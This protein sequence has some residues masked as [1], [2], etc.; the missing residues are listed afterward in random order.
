M[1]TPPSYRSTVA[2][3]W[4]PGCGNFGIHMA[5]QKALTSLTI[6]PHDVLLCFDVGC[7]GNMSD[8]I[9]GYRIHG[10]HGRVIPLASGA[11][12]ANRRVK[13]IAMGGD[14]ATYGEGVNHFLHAFRSNYDITF[15]CHNN[16]TYGLTTGQASPTTP[17]GSAMPG[18]PGGHAESIFDPIRTAFSLTPSFIARGHSARF[19]DLATIIAAGIQHPGFSYIDIIQACPTYVRN[20]SYDTIQENM[21]EVDY[22]IHDLTTARAANASESIFHGILYADPASVSFYDRISERQGSTTELVDEVTTHDITQY[23]GDFR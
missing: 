5:L 14:G 12:L 6:S 11:A 21:C 10:L 15:L 9:G 16:G 8:K 1:T 13:I 3:T 18:Q 4:C 17:A 22:D 23:L 7:N 20:K 2:P 19:Q